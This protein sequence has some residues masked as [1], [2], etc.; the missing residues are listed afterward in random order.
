MLSS[1]G[2]DE[3]CCL[4]DNQVISN[5]TSR[6]NHKDVLRR[7]GVLSKTESVIVRKGTILKYFPLILTIQWHC[8]ND[9]A[10]QKAL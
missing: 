3:R 7:N 8:F 1:S 6:Q 2:V 10:K 4:Q 5:E 9:F